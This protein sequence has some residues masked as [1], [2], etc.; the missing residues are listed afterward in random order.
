[1]VLEFGDLIHTHVSG[2]QC[3]TDTHGIWINGRSCKYETLLIPPNDAASTRQEDTGAHKSIIASLEER[4]VVNRAC[5]L[6]VF[7]TN[8]SRDTLNGCRLA[9]SMLINN[10]FWI[11][12][13]FRST[14]GRSFSCSTTRRLKSTSLWSTSHVYFA[15]TPRWLLHNTYY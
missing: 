15:P 10:L 11:E 2:E 7:H 9:T 6:S 12:G 13:E 8:G 14:S 3:C 4:V 5:C 1:M